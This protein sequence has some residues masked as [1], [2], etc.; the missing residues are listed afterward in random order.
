[1]KQRF[2][3]ILTILRLVDKYEVNTQFSHL[4]I[5]SSKHFIYPHTDCIFVSGA[6]TGSGTQ[7]NKER[8]NI[9]REM[10]KCYFMIQ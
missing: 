4:A 10:R 3:I 8:G 1:M 7:E 2:P 5:S 9:W 6:E